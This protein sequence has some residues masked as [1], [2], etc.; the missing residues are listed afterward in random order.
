M[1]KKMIK[2]LKRTTNN[3]NSKVK[4]NKKNYLK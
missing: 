1:T 2:K 3:K 4:I